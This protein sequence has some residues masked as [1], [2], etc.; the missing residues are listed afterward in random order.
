M[1]EHLIF[2]LYGPIVSWGGIAVGEERPSYAYPTK[3]AVIGMVEAALGIRGD[4]EE[5]HR[6]LYDALGYAVEVYS[7]GNPLRDYNTVMTPETQKNRKFSTRKDELMLDKEEIN[8]ITSCRDYITDAC[9]KVCLWE[10]GEGSY[11]LR[12]IKEA[13][14]EPEFVLYLGRKACPPALFFNPLLVQT[15]TLLEAL[16]KVDLSDIEI[17]SPIQREKNRHIYWDEH[18]S[19]GMEVTEQIVKRDKIANRRLWQFFNRLEYHTVI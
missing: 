16:N 13:L 19:P 7:F 3:S 5:K 1:M 10:K 4:E 6:Q 2:C 9:Y 17:L 15:D 8:T 12:E 11:T 18:L 14:I